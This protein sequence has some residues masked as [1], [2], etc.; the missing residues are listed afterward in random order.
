MEEDELTDEE[1]EEE[2]EAVEKELQNNQGYI[3]KFKALQNRL[4][5]VTNRLDRL[6]LKGVESTLLTER[7]NRIK[8]LQE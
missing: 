7:Y 5:A 1:I 8:E 4:N 3:G 2:V 6:S